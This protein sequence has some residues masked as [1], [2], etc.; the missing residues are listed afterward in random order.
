MEMYFT[1]MSLAHLK[2]NEMGGTCN[3]HWRDE[4]CIWFENLKGRDHWK[5]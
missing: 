3:T 2:D 4:K 1:Y 5:Y